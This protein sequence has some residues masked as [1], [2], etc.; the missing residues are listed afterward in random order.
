LAV[1]PP[2]T[3]NP[4]DQCFSLRPCQNGGTCVSRGNQGGY[5]CTCP[6]GYI[7]V[8][9]EAFSKQIEFKKESIFL[10]SRFVGYLT[11][12][13]TIPSK[14]C[15]QSSLKI[16]LS[17]PGFGRI[18]GGTPV[19]NHTWP[20]IVSIQTASRQHF[21]SIYKQWSSIEIKLFLIFSVVVL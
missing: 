14:T 20:W 1:G 17:L 12:P 10:S 4:N 15:G 8:N 7:G 2:T 13:S 6:P 11:N 21:V 19:K 3:Y 9:C 18:V 5:T 16:P